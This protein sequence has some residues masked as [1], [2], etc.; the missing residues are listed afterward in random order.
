MRKQNFRFESKYNFFANFIFAYT[1]IKLHHAL[2]FRSHSPVLISF[3]HVRVSRM[4]LPQ[5]I[6]SS[7]LKISIYTLL[8]SVVAQIDCKNSYYLKILRSQKSPNS[9][10]CVILDSQ[11][12]PKAHEITTTSLHPQENY[13]PHNEEILE[14]FSQDSHTA[15]SYLSKNRFCTKLLEDSL[16][17]PKNV[18][19]SQSQVEI[20]RLM[21]NGNSSNRIDVVFM[22]DGYTLDEKS[23]FFSDIATLIEGT[24]HSGTYR[25]FLPLLNIWGIF[26]PSVDS[27]IGYNGRTKNTPFKLYRD[28]GPL[29]SV[30]T[31]AAP[32]ARRVCK[33]TGVSG[34]DYPILLGNDDYYGGLGGEF[35]IATSSPTSGVSI[36]RHELGHNFAKVG[37]EYDSGQV[38][39]G[40]NSS[41]NL[42]RIKWKKWLSRGSN[43]SVKEERMAQRISSYP[44][45]NNL[46]RLIKSNKGLSYEFRS[47]GSYSSWGLFVSLSGVKDVEGISVSLD[48]ERL[49]WG[50]RSGSLDKVLYDWTNSSDNSGGLSRGK[51]KLEVKALYPVIGAE[52]SIP[53]TVGSV[54]LFEYG[55]E[56]QSDL[57]F[58]SAYP[59]WDIYGR[60]RFRPTNAGCLMRN[61]SHPNLCSVCNEAVWLQFM[62]RIS[63]IDELKVDGNNVEL[64]TLKLGQFRE[65][66]LIPGE[67][68]EVRWF[69]NDEEM[70]ELEGRS[71]ITDLDEGKWTLRVELK[72]DEVR[73]DPNRLLE[74]KMSFVIIAN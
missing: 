6:P 15:E 7:Y 62:Q 45:K 29:R 68:V 53:R 36:L 27:G 63:L 69:R 59:T 48:G 14:I 31:K 49:P 35:A 64:K 8:A 61:M 21:D 39:T 33:M 46:D 34:C 42:S 58:I 37:E 32:F 9:T 19:I 16:E 70:K 67:R 25:N 60:K 74:E 65:D 41:P 72:T 71:E 23:K 20:R 56:Y 3:N 11:L 43:S 54:G 51:H 44:S 57:D 22:G 12:I 24:F 50:N 2:L 30:F 73:N 66:A 18:K 38:Y 1:S 10:T 13:L 5:N 4:K 47:D 28:K 17:E 52:A 40:A 26:V 55:K